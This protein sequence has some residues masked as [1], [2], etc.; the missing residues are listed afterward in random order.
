MTEGDEINWNGEEVGSE[1]GRKWS[2]Q[3]QDSRGRR[4]LRFHT[5]VFSNKCRHINFERATCLLVKCTPSYFTNKSHTILHIRSLNPIN[6]CLT[7]K[8][9]Q[10]ILQLF[11]TCT[12]KIITPVSRTLLRRIFS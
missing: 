6:F 1:R 9:G 12:R 7:L 3:K 2:W 8:K 11:K 10:M 5:A 4:H